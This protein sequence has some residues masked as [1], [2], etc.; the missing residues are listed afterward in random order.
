M[1]QSSNTMVNTHEI[2]KMWP[3]SSDEAKHIVGRMETIYKYW[4]DSVNC[5]DASAWKENEK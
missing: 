2:D 4:S 3:P 1:L 5:D